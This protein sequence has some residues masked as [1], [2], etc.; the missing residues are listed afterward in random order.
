M[1]ESLIHRRTLLWLLAAGLLLGGLAW[2]SAPSAEPGR[3]TLPSYYPTAFDGR[4]IINRLG[5]G[6]IVI[7]DM[8]YPLAARPVYNTPQMQDSSK[9]SFEAGSR[10][11]Y[12]LN[13][14]GE[15]ASLWLIN[16]YVDP[17]MD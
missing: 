7:N 9:L 15:I 12:I 16:D 5:D 3:K 8:E 2:P 13:D 6:E 17:R 10:I 11:G 14:Q 1:F 4:G